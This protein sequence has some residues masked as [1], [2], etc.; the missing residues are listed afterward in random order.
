MRVLTL[1]GARPQFIKASMLSRA[2]ANFGVEEILIHSGQHYDRKISQVFF[3][4]LGLPIPVQNL[5]VGSGSHA[6]Q[7]GEIMIRL[8]TAIN[9][10]GK[11][12]ALIVYGDTNTTIAGALV[13]VKRGIR[14]IHVEAGLRS[15]N[16][17]MPEEI[18]RVTTDCIS[19]VLFCP[20]QTAMSNLQNEGITDGVYLSG[21]VMFDATIFFAELAEKR[22]EKPEFSNGYYLATVHR[23]ANTDNSEKL[24]AI[25]QGLG[26]VRKKVVLPLHPRTRPKIHDI[27]IP[28]NVI[29]T[30]P[31][32]YL[33]MLNLIKNAQAVLTDSGG[34]QKEAFWLQRPC[35]T[36]REETEWVETLVGGWNQ[37]VGAD[38]VRMLAA[39]QN[40]PLGHERRI[41]FGLSE[42]GTMSASFIARCLTKL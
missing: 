8:D 42:D 30:D 15:F 24:K 25:M 27:K 39:I 14:L 36:L 16:R 28:Q 40:M 12:D 22:L 6:L 29:I 41:D 11:V 37:L 18:N 13:A 21:D 4:E 1:V 19:D 17:T 31:V 9:E 2:L 7:T 26:K 20:T 35:I 34:L 5:H 10:L 23:A 33:E 38:P 32:G 3:E